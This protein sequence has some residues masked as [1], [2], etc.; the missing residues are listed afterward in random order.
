MRDQP[1]V[2]PFGSLPGRKFFLSLIAIFMALFALT[3]ILS[4]PAQAQPA[5]AKWSGNSILYNGHQYVHMGEAKAG[6]S[7]GIPAGSPIYAYIEPAPG[8]SPTTPRKAHI[9]YFTPGTD[10]PT[11]TSATLASFDF[12]NGTFSNPGATQGITIEPNTGNSGTQSCDSGQFLKGIGWIICP[13]TNFL[14]G[15][16]DWLYGI[17]SDFLA[18]RPMQTTQDNALFRAWSFMRNFANVAFVIAFLIVIYS[19]LSGVG[20]SNY[21]VKKLLPKLIIAAILVNVSYWICTVAI[22]LSNIA[23]YSIQNI[24]IDIRNNLVGPEGNSWDISWSD[25]ANFILAGGAGIGVGVG[26]YALAAG[27][28]GGAIYMLLPILVGVGLA[29]L[30]AL[31]VM[32]LRQALITILTVVSPLAFVAFLLPN[33]EKYFDKWK[34]VFGTMLVMFPIFSMIFGGSQLAGALIIQNANSITVIILGMAVQVAP[35]V[36]TPLLVKF[37]GA[38]ISRVAGMVNN[39]NRGLIDRTRNWAQQQKDE[40][41]ARVLAST[42]KNGIRGFTARRT[43]NIEN[44]RRRGKEWKAANEA[45]ADAKWHNSADYRKIHAAGER[46]HMLKER[47]EALAEAHVNQLKTVNGHQMQVDETNLHVAKLQVDVTKA[48]IDAMHE[49][50]RAGSVPHASLAGQVQTAQDATRDLA[51]TAMRKA[52]AERTQ[53]N[54]LTQ[55]LLNNKTTID[56]QTLRE[57][58]GG[59]RGQDG[60]DSVL[61]SSVTAYREE[62]GKMV[63]E[64]SQLIK[65]FNLDSG[66]RQNLALGDNVIGERVE[67]DGR[68]VRFTFRNDDHYAREAAVEAQMKTG[69]EGQIITLIKESGTYI[70]A[71]G[72]LA[73]GKTYEYRQTISDDIPSNGIPGKSLIFGSKIINDVSQGAVYGDEGLKN[74]AIYHIMD[75]KIRD[76]VLAVQGAETLKILYEVGKT[77][78]FE[79]LK[80]LPQYANASEEKKRA[81]HENYE[82][83][84]RSAATI[85]ADKINRNTSEAAREVFKKNVPE[86]DHQP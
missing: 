81:F 68:V 74:A 28:V 78:N 85:L 13:V 11:A 52:A 49:E 24:F 34:D 43:Q 54:D 71:N 40:H 14:A 42:P 55:A 46:A 7:H 60:A 64:K 45:Y 25:L 39:P 15:A 53:K 72:N 22:D 38:L 76:D 17:L 12:L 36:V 4:Q 3:T 21:G 27:S 23:G 8:G 29:I 56:G 83:L 44:R 26:L 37:S 73:K 30:V 2:L 57:Y 65:H 16:M 18:V 84:R 59:I 32:A 61:A 70:D 31:L 62:F 20:I 66:A 9:I 86:D 48:R 51:L 67:D 50:M 5:G 41:K 35:V 6:D 58:A 47:G 33:T 80:K 82:S 79:E 1:L 77:S 19:Q 69:S 75:G 10:P 63:A